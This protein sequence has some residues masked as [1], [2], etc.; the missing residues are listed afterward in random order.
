M[1]K[2]EK[3][4]FEDMIKNKFGAEKVELVENKS[5]LFYPEFFIIVVVAL[6]FIANYLGH[7]SENTK[8]IADTLQSADKVSIQKTVNERIVK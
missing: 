1:D 5:E 7:I 6:I 4:D 8:S 2:N 3:K